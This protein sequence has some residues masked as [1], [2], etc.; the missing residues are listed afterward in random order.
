MFLMFLL[1][2]TNKSRKGT[3]KSTDLNCFLFVLIFKA[4]SSFRLFD[5][6]ACAFFPFFS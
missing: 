6:L 5:Y 4:S 1:L 3:F 2:E